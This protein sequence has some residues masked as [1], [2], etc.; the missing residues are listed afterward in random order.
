MQTIIETYQKAKTK[1]INKSNLY[2]VYFVVSPI[3]RKL[4]PIMKVKYLLYYI[5]SSY[6]N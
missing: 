1:A 3:R 5:G 6:I 4:L 2:S